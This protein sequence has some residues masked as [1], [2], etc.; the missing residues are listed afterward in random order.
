VSKATA[1]ASRHVAYAM[2]FINDP[3]A[4]EPTDGE[5]E[6]VSYGCA[7]RPR[8]EEYPKIRAEV[9]AW[10]AYGLTM[11]ELAEL[12]DPTPVFTVTLGDLQRI[13]GRK[14]DDDEIADLHNTLAGPDFADQVSAAVTAALPDGRYV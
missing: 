1:L 7:R 8:P 12:E 10:R 11:A 13:A 14:L 6:R 9:E 3:S 5:I 4:G 2:H